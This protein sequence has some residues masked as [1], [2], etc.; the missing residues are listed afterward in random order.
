M[1]TIWNGTLELGELVIP[2]GLASAVREYNAELRTLHVA[3]KTPIRLR[4]YCQ[5]DEKLLE[6]EELVRAFEIAP[7]EGFLT[8]LSD[9][10]SA[11]KEPD[12]RRI[13]ISCFTPT[14]AID[15]RLVKKHYHLIPSS[16]IGLDAYALLVCAIA[17]QNVAAI[18]R[19]AWRGE[20]IAA[21]TSHEGLLDLAVLYFA[22]DI[23]E[24]DVWQLAD[25]LGVQTR[26]LSDD[27]LKLARKLVDRHTRPLNDVD[28]ASE[29]RP[30]MTALRQQLLDNKPVT[31]PAVKKAK[32]AAAPT[33][34]LAGALKRSVKQAP[35]A[36]ERRRAAALAR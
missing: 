15:P 26:P 7:G 9:D 6:P 13:P 23:V 27:L 17:E 31:R 24:S 18:V 5:V 10:L 33:A 30:R 22:E 8:P 20:K 28:L 36:A 1:D 19:F 3:C 4:P 35:T 32:E 11:V 16:E 25:Q 12:T 34:D 21:I 2:V 14:S 29:E